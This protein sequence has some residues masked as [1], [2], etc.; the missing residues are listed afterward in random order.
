MTT[1][2]VLKYHHQLLDLW[3]ERSVAGIGLDHIDFH[4]DM[5]GLFVDPGRSNV[6][7][8]GDEPGG[9]DEGNFISHAIMEDRIKDVTWV[10]DLPGGR[11]FD[12]NGVVLEGDLA[13]YLP[14]KQPRP[15]TFRGGLGYREMTLERWKGPST[16]RWLDIDWDTFACLDI[17]RASLNHRVASFFDRLSQ[18]GAGKPEHISV[19]YSPGYSH[20]T[21]NE[22]KTF[23]ENL[24]ALYG[25]TVEERNWVEEPEAKTPSLKHLVPPPVRNILRENAFRA[26]R[27]LRQRGIF[28]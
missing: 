15:S 10:H 20:P 17:P 27:A 19:C 23:V 14:W 2:F 13:R 1:I 6:A 12:V 22:F 28:L 4:C 8:V 11:A 3:R 5:R 18:A 24:R 7:W 9:L 21:Q 26:H 16:D 25:A